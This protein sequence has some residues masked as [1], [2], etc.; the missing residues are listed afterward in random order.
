MSR[1]WGV[2]LGLPLLKFAD[3]GAEHSADFGCFFQERSDRFRRA[4]FHFMCENQ[5]RFKFFQAALSDTQEMNVFSCGFAAVAF[6]D[7]GRDRRSRAAD[8]AGQP[9]QLFSGKPARQ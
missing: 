7:I 8:L 3:Q 4:Q 1:E 9:E 2:G 6:S 5:M